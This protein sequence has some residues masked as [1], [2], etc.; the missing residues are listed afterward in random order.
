MFGCVYLVPFEFNGCTTAYIHD[1]FYY[2]W[3]LG[4]IF[5]I[6]P[7]KPVAVIYRGR[8]EGYHALLTGMQAGS[9]KGNLLFQ[10]SLMNEHFLTVAPAESCGRKYMN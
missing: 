7:Y 1:I 8:L 3:Y 9:L 2:C 6:G 5:N 4:A 10:C